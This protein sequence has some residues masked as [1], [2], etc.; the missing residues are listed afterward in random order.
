MDDTP[1]KPPTPQKVRPAWARENQQVK[2]AS[3]DLRTKYG[4]CGPGNTLSASEWMEV[5]ALVALA[6]ALARHD[7]PV[8]FKPRR[9]SVYGGLRAKAGAEEKRCCTIDQFSNDHG[10]WQALGELEALPS[11]ATVKGH[12]ETL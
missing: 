9:W 10:H 2:V 4:V 12:L 11:H 7:H 1:L 6:A 5:S 3:D 8:S